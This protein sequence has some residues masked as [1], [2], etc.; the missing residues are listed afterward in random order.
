MRWVGQCSVDWQEGD[1]ES[2]IRGA[3]SYDHTPISSSDT[4]LRAR[5]VATVARVAAMGFTGRTSSLEGDGEV[6]EAFSEDAG[7]W[8]SLTGERRLAAYVAKRTHGDAEVLERSLSKITGGREA[9]WHAGPQ[10]EGRAEEPGV[11][12]WM[13]EFDRLLAASCGTSD[14]PSFVAAATAGD[15]V[16]D[17]GYRDGDNVTLRALTGLDP[18]TYQ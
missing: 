2:P 6:R 3:G 7:S 11:P 17:G 16:Y 9:D 1:G 13:T 18:A 4:E 8:P 5:P 15:T 12:A 10:R 14:D